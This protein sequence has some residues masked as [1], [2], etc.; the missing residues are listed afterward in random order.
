[1]ASSSSL[2]DFV[3]CALCPEVFSSNE[4]LQKH[5]ATHFDAQTADDMLREKLLLSQTM[6]KKKKKKK[7]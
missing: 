7:E 6:R 4:L 3:K 2:M 5:T 1:M